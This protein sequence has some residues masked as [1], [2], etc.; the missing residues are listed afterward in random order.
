MKISNSHTKYYKQYGFLKLDNF[1]TN[2]EILSFKKEVNK[3]KKSKSKKIAKYYQLN[4]SG[5]KNH[6]NRIEYFYSY[7]KI[8][9]NLIDSKKVSKLLFSLTKKKYML[10]KEKINIKPANS[11]EDRLHQDVQ[12]DWLKYSKN[13]ITLLISL[14]KTNNKNGNLIIDVSGHNKDQIRGKMFEVLKSKQLKKPKFKNQPTMPGDILLFNGFTPHKSTKNLTN[15]SRDQ[16]YITYCETKNKN[17]RQKYFKEKFSNCPPN[18]KDNNKKFA[19][20][21]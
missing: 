9:K 1:Y 12:G 16:I 10:F 11:R 3:L 17:T 5:N 2:K 14:V 20:K 8:L 6:L 4:L 19:F 21:N 15:K 18:I 7:S 13:F